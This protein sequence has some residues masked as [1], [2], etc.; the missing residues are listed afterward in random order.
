MNALLRTTALYSRAAIV[1]I[2][3]TCGTMQGT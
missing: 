1:K 3:F 2:L